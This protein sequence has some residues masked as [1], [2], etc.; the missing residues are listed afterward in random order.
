MPPERVFP[1]LLEDDGKPI[2]MAK[3]Q[4]Y[5]PKIKTRDVHI[6]DGRKK[7]SIKITKKGHRM[8]KYR[9]NKTARDK[10]RISDRNRKRKMLASETEEQR[11]ERNRKRREKYKE[12][13]KSQ[14][15]L[16]YI[17]PS[18]PYELPIE[19]NDIDEGRVYKQQTVTHIERVNYI[20]H[21]VVPV[22]QPDPYLPETWESVVQK[23]KGKV[24]S[25]VI[26]ETRRLK[27]TEVV[28]GDPNLA[29]ICKRFQ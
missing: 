29:G 20:F 17:K 22:E 1:E 13:I 11:Q 4:K 26:K 28:E 5:Y 24:V 9:L 23:S 10:E 21:D 7:K 15:E 25:K 16:Q 18:K 2:R 14:N 19:S 8:R 27:G 12:K 3:S 6:R